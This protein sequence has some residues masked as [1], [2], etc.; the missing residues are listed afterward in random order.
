[1]DITIFKTAA[2]TATR[3]ASR[4]LLHGKKSSPTILLGAGIVGFVSTIVLASRATMKVE[5]IVNDTIEYLDIIEVGKRNGHLTRTQYH[6]QRA[7]VI[8]NQGAKVL[9]VYSPAIVVGFAT[10]GCF[11]GSNVVLQRRNAALASAYAALDDS[12]QRYRSRVQKKY[13]ID[14]ERSLYASDENGRALESP[15]QQTDFSIPSNSQK[16]SPYA[17]WFDE[18]SSNWRRNADYN[19]LF[20]RSQ[21]N[22]ANHMLKS[23]GHV[24]LNEVYDMLDMP[25]SR[26]GAI[27]GWT[28]DPK[29]GDCYIDFGIYEPTEEKISFVNGHEK[30]I[31]LDF[32]VDGIIYDR[33]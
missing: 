26:A 30:S 8:L 14:E 13:G 17:R 15:E 6:Q 23:R 19:L 32:N 33:I 11:V 20:L 21:Q 16:L 12:F 31:L 27:V 9:H 18:M 3:F 7:T 22:Y 5:P 1:M 29:R 28:L 2:A 24:F 25:R 10:I 4:T